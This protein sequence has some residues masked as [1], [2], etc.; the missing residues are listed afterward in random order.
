MNTKE[1][2]AKYTNSGR[3]SRAQMAF[4]VFIISLFFFMLTVIIFLAIQKEYSEE[5]R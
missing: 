3:P 4:G 1:N 2:L 5:V